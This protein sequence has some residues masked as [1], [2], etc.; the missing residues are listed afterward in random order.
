MLAALRLAQKAFDEGEVPIGAVVVKQ[1]NI[2]GQGYNRRETDFDPTAHAEVVAIREAARN[3][4]SWRL[5]GSWLYVTVEPCAMCA[6]AI[7]NARIEKLVFGCY[8][9][10]AGAC[11]SLINLPSDKR[12]NHRVEIVPGIMENQARDLMQEFFRRLRM[13]ER[14][15]SLVEGD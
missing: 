11:G 13:K 14:W 12:L 3:E 9:P 2:I 7:V 15:P 8:D 5:E 4:K 6:G 1:G 10:K